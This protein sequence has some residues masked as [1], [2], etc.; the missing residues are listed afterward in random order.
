MRRHVLCALV[1][2]AIG[3]SGAVDQ[4]LQ[5]QQKLAAANAH[6]Q[7]TQS[8]DACAKN[9]WYGESRTS[10]ENAVSAA[11]D[12]SLSRDTLTHSLTGY[13]VIER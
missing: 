10:P 9:R 4:A 6:A 13:A 8:G 2:T 7:G 11:D 3:C 1:L 5:Q 12:V